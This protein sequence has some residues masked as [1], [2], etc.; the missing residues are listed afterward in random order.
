MINVTIASSPTIST[1]HLPPV[2]ETAP[3]TDISVTMAVNKPKE[4][5]QLGDGLGS[6]STVDYNSHVSLS[7]SLSTQQQLQPHAWNRGMKILLGSKVSI[8]ATC[9]TLVM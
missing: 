8:T 7:G 2:E 9:D 5:Q 6:S 4:E 3:E 1:V